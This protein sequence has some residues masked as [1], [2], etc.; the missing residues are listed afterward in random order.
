[1][2]EH[3]KTLSL[4]IPTLNA[5]GL[6]G[7]LLDAVEAQTARPDEVLVVDSSSDDD[8]VNI[9]ESHGARVIT[10]ARAEFDHGGTRTLAAREARGD[11]LVFMTQDALLADS[12]SIEKLVHPFSQREKTAAVFGNQI[13]HPGASPLS[14]YLR[15]FNYPGES[16]R[17]S[18]GDAARYGIKTAFLSNSFAA[19]RR[20]A[21]EEVG[22]FKEDLILGEDT[23]TGARL[24]LAGYEIEYVA[25]AVAY[26]SHEYGVAQEFRRYFDI[27]VF[28][29]S[30]DWIIKEFGRAES[31]GGRYIRSGLSYLSSHGLRRMIP[32]FIARGAAKYLGYRLGRSFKRLPSS[33]ATMCSM[34]RGWWLK[35]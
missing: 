23:Y 2:S 9:A 17:R 11:L 3:R 30:E 24:L 7:K 27:G 8:T 34:H 28:H 26:H 16:Y 1:M 31:E 19:Y 6:L 20:G 29:S 22:W 25:E 10:V 12:H 13:P 32:G 4:I 15:A 14:A 5:G 33:F 18:R 35:R 21:L